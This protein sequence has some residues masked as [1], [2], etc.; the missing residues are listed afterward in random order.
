MNNET[1]EKFMIL[2]SQMHEDQNM[3]LC[4]CRDRCGKYPVSGQGLTVQHGEVREPD[5]FRHEQYLTV[6]ENG[7]RIVFSGCSHR[8]V[9]NIVEWMRPD[10]LVGG[11]HFKKLDPDGEGR[12]AL[13]SAAGT[14][15]QGE[16][17]YYTGHCTGDAQFDFLKVRMGER[18]HG[19]YTGLEIVL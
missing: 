4:D 6:I 14:L 2:L 7:R 10:V 1:K 13:E 17:I 12:A 16:T 15:M 3:F 18:L 11:F 5:D 9:L 8:G 19:L